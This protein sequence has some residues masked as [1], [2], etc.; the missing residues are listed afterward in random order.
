LERAQKVAALKLLAAF[1]ISVKHHL[2]GEH[3][4]LWEDYEGILVAVPNAR[5]EVDYVN[6]AS[7][8]AS[9]ETRPLLAAQHHHVDH[10]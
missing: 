1:A 9:D 7:G 10:Q 4:D 6:N 8:S 2:R 5:T 3:G